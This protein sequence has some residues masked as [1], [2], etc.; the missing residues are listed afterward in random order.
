MSTGGRG[1]SDA[2]CKS[3]KFTLSI[4]IVIILLGLSTVSAGSPD[5]ETQFTSNT[6]ATSTSPDITPMEQR[7]LDH[8]NSATTSIDLAIYDFNRD[9]IRDALIA[10]HG[11]GVSV[12]VVTDD[13]ASEHN[14]TYKPYYDALKS[15][16]ITVIDDN[17]PSDIMHNKFWVFDGT[18]VWTGSTNIT[19]NGFTK[20]HNNSLIFNS[21]EIATIFTDQFEQMFV[22]GN[23][24]T[25]KSPSSTTSL[26]YGD[27]PL[28]I[29]FSPK[30]DALDEVIAEVNAAQE[31]IYFSI[32]FFTSDGLRD[33]LIAA[34]QRG[35]TIRGV[36]DLLGASNSYS[37]DEALCAAGIPIKIETYIGKMHNKFMLIDANGDNPRTIT[38]SMNWTN[39]G[40]NKNDENTVIVH[41]MITTQAF[42]GFWDILYND[43]GAE[44]LCIPEP[45][46]HTLYLPI[47]IDDGDPAPQTAVMQ[48][49]TILYNPDGNDAEGEVV[50]IQ[51]IGNGP[52]DLT[53]W[54]LHD[55][56]NIIYT[57]PSFTLQPMRSVNIWV[58]T[59]FD[60]EGNLFWGRGSPVW[61][62]SGDT[63][64]LL[65]A[66]GLVIDTCAYPGGEQ[67]YVCP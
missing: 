54:T 25:A 21:A 56:A 19:D 20:N 5:P 11:R 50:E 32:F 28:E 65:N 63:A 26:T 35:V 66:Q 22:N 57:F 45:D 2:L 34:H 18:I 16:G 14:A 30:D 39:S 13:E 7:L 33:A 17:R 37:D 47:L 40:D 3:R 12:R 51:N 52:Q 49:N 60:N 41:D 59:G 55:E 31:S 29:Y 44:T 27:I 38:G 23:F 6:A 8:I 36:W 67:G 48:I 42:K 24:S 58:T 10:A 43:L 64:T 62:N 9:S 46:H 61:N 1:A 53:G 15:A 4:F